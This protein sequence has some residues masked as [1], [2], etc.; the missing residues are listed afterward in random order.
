MATGWSGEVERAMDKS[1][2][3]VCLIRS[4]HTTH[5]FRFNQTVVT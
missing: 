1:K 3:R 5:N 4:V 2:L